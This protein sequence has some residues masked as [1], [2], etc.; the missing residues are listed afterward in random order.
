MTDI[1]AKKNHCIHYPNL[2]PN[3]AFQAPCLCKYQDI[4]IEHAVFFAAC[5]RTLSK[6]AILWMF[7]C[8]TVYHNMVIYDNVMKHCMTTKHS[9]NQS[10]PVH[11]SVAV[12]AGLSLRSPRKLFFF[13]IKKYFYRIK[14][15]KKIINLILKKTSLPPTRIFWNN[16]FRVW[17][18]LI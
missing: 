7:R 17:D 12:L 5:L 3:A 16:V 6:T 13:F 14:V 8:R 18:I 2:V 4:L 10:V 11:I 9:Q 1:S 15:S